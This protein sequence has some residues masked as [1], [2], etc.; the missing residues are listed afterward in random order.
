MRGRGELSMA[1]VGLKSRGAQ[2][3]SIKIK[4]TIEED[5]PK[6]QTSQQRKKRAKYNQNEQKDILRH[7]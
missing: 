4:L 7:D 3:N 6:Q 2:E 1:F 5:F